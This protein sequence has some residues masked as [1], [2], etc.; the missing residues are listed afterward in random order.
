MFYFQGEGA[1]LLVQLSIS[2]LL[3]CFEKQNLKIASF[4]TAKLKGLNLPPVSI[5]PCLT[6]VNSSLTLKLKIPKFQENATYATIG[7][8]CFS[9]KTEVELYM[10]LSKNV[11]KL[12]EK[13]PVHVECTVIGGSAQVEKVNQK[14]KI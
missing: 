9:G 10:K 14:M 3:S 8:S 13:I 1:L 12:G 7:G 4:P 2:F 11:F 6:S 5:F